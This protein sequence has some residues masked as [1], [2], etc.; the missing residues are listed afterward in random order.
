MSIQFTYWPA[1]LLLPLLLPYFWWQQ[2]RTVTDLSPKRRRVALALRV[3]IV[4]LLVLVLAGTQWVKQGDSLAV[5]F[6][7]DASKSVRDDQKQVME[8]YLRDAVRGMRDVDKTGLITFG[9]NPHTQSSPGQP[10][11]PT[12][13]SDTGQTTATD[14]AQALRLA[15][16]ELDT[17]ARGSGK[18]IV[19]LSDGNENIGRALAEVPELTAGNIVLDTITLPVGAREEVLVEKTLL[20]ARV[21][22]GE[23][24]PVRVVVNS[25]SAQSAVVALT[26]DNQPAAPA[27]RVELRP[28]KNVIVFEQNV[29]KA[30]FVRYGVSLDAPQDEVKENNRGEG[31]VWVRGKPSV[32]YVG[33][34]AAPTQFLRRALAAQN[35]TV[36]YTSPDG[37]PGTAAALQRYDSVLF[38]N[39]PRFAFTDVQLRALQVSTRDFGVGFTMIGGEQ[40]YGVGAYRQSVVEEMLP[41]SMD[42]RKMQRFPSV[43]VA[44]AIDRSGSMGEGAPKTKLE[45]ALDAAARTV[46]ALKP[47]DKVAVITFEDSAEVRVPLTDV[48]Q[49][50]AI[51]GQIQRINIGGGTSV[52]SGVSL[53]YDTIKDD[54]TPIKHLIILTDG[55][56]ADPDYT[57]L[58]NGMKARKI[59]LTGVVIGAGTNDLYKHDLKKVAKA[60]GGRFYQVDNE[61]QIP[62]IYLQE[63]ERISSKPIEEEPFLPQATELAEAIIPGGA[64]QKLP[65]LLGYNVVQP[66]PT[67]DLLILSPKKDPILA[68]WRYGLGR[69]AAFTSD[70]RNRWAAHWLRWGDYP[71]FWAELVRWTLRSNTPSEYAT[72]V[73]ME[74]NRAHIVVDAIDNEGKYVNR[75]SLRAKISAPDE[76]GLQSDT[77]REEILRQTGPG[78]YEG[79]FDAPQLGTYLVNVLQK[80]PGNAPD[81]STV[82]GLS[83]AYSPEYKDT[84]SNDYLMM[85]LAQAGNG[86]ENP[87]PSAVFGSDRPTG[88]R[89]P[90]D[91]TL[92]LL[93][94]TMALLPFDIAVRRLAIDFADVRRALAYLRGRVPK[95]AESAAPPELSRL[96]GRKDAVVAAREEALR[97]HDG[98]TGPI[99]VPTPVT[100][101]AKTAGRAL[102][103]ERPMT[104]DVNPHIGTQER[105]NSPAPTP[106]HT[107]TR[108]PASAPPASVAD[109]SL[110]QTDAEPAGSERAGMS[111]LMA[112]KRR[113]QERQHKEQ[114]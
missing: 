101:M 94:L 18:R 59:T 64:W 12:R 3:V 96:R 106:V 92:P 55:M 81:T 61:K 38:S 47:S 100:T 42:I 13:L 29:D 68:T 41:V 67:A 34:D 77:V 111:R 45:L 79:W 20:P 83:T 14:I 107:S 104:E 71:R 103:N 114:E 65:M 36:D 21:K 28:G 50:D 53:A 48:E 49:G 76:R 89:P 7:A 8:A 6:V 9:Q 26:R 87:P 24:F 1:L 85:Q 52:Y 95:Q 78:R 73:T 43:V 22:I 91:M 10:L 27:K 15:K 109:A 97:P 23:P 31:F 57:A 62:G 2:R 72:Q 98:E 30:G 105:S 32:L 90:H 99:T 66:K 40:S 60:T 51:I 86:R 88:G 93:F 11:D 37:F 84:Q 33:D 44:T 112:A 56:S 74:G 110:A 25:L 102:H 75:L 58:I 80:Q 35:I 46:R 54:A 5:V 4:T 113:A 82:V 69:V 108:S 16:N 63:I 17:M 19:L 39:V 70:D